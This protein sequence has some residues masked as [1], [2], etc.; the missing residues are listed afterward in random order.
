MSMASL[1]TNDTKWSLFLM[2]N[3]R[4]SSNIY[5]INNKIQVPNFKKTGISPSRS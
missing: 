3:I 5:G 2:Y 1:I 4:S